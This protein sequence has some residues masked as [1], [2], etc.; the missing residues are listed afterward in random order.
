MQ[1]HVSGPC[2]VKFGTAGGTEIGTCKN[3]VRIEARTNWIPVTDQL[4]GNTPA[5][6]IF[7]GKSATVTM[8]GLDCSKLKTAKTSLWPMTMLSTG[9]STYIGKT[10]SAMAC[11]LEILENGS[12]TADWVALWAVC[13]QPSE[14]VLS[15]VQEVQVPLVWL[16]LPDAS[17]KLFDTYP[18]WLKPTA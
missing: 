2:I 12:D 13:R 4:H 17:K 10:A 16:I 11:Q 15:S 18:A 14:L 9:G 3:G 7:G 6:Y 1:Y 8:L 5:T